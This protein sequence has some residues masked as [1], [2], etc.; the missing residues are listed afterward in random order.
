MK[1]DK[2]KLLVFLVTALLLLNLG[3]LSFLFLQNNKGPHK[4]QNRPHKTPESIITKRLQLDKKQIEIYKTAIQLH[5]S[6]IKELERERREL[7]E[8]LYNQLN[9]NDSIIENEILLS[10]AKNQKEIELNHLN[11]FKA[12]QSLCNEDQQDEFIELINDLGKMFNRPPP[13]K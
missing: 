2:N 13:R 5:R 6:Q 12:I 1:L 4:K 10:L 9:V 3:T 7:K 8:N 11:H